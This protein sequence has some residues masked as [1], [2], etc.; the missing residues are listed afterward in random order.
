MALLKRTVESSFYPA[1]ETRCRPR[2]KRHN[3]ASPA[4]LRKQP[5]HE[6]VRAVRGIPGVVVESQ[7]LR[8][9]HVCPRRLQS[10]RG[11]A[12]AVD[13]HNLVD[14]TVEDPNW[15]LAEVLRESGHDRRAVARNHG[16]RA[17]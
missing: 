2:P 12:R 9:L 6:F 10:R 11:L 1:F 5:A 15:N 3:R 14:L 17:A 7:Q 8:V 4:L 16:D 13:I